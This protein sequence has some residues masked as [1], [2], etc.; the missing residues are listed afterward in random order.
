MRKEENVSKTTL[1]VT[2]DDATFGRA[3][4]ALAGVDHG[5]KIT[6]DTLGHRALTAVLNTIGEAVEGGVS[7]KTCFKCRHAR[8]LEGLAKFPNGMDSKFSTVL[9]VAIGMLRGLA[10]RVNAQRDNPT[11]V[12]NPADGAAN[13][14]EVD[15]IHLTIKNLDDRVRIYS[16]I[17]R[18]FREEEG[19]HDPPDGFEII[20]D[21]PAMDD[22]PKVDDPRELP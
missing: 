21:F 14:A 20:E 3:V 16:G 11:I 10:V 9:I 17:I 8:D 12:R 19:R 7:P 5:G 13:R 18:H 15:A 2:L 1:T 22:P 6:S 4:E